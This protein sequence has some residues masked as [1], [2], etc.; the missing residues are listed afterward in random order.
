MPSLAY[1]HRTIV[2]AEAQQNVMEESTSTN[3]VI[4]AVACAQP[5]SVYDPLPKPGALQ[6]SFPDG[7]PEGGTEDITRPTDL[8]G[9]VLNN[10]AKVCDY[11]KGDS[12]DYP[13]TTGSKILPDTT[14]WPLASDPVKRASSACKLAVYDWLRRA[15]TKANV[16]SF[17]GAQGTPFDAQGADVPWGTAAP[18]PAPPVSIATI[19]RGIVHIYRFAPDGVVTYQSKDQQPQKYYV[20]ADGQVFMECFEPITDGVPGFEIGDPPPPAISLGA[21]ISASDG[22]VEFGSGYDMHIRLYSRRPGV[23]NGRHAGEPLDNPVVATRP[24]TVKLVDTSSGKASVD[25]MTI[26]GRGAASKKW[27]M[28][29]S[30]PPTPGSLGVPP[31]II[32][33]VDFMQSAPGLVNPAASWYEMY[34]APGSGV[35]VTYQQQNGTVSDIRFRRCV[36]V[37]S[38]AAPDVV[39]TGYVGSRFP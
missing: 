8:Y 38:K 24:A 2:R 37:W 29:T 33:R 28:K 34:D 30:G 16:S 23:M 3:H 15:G 27:W 22:V 19:P 31:D 5:A 35:R 20:V 9:P 4:R 10:A 17:I 36:A 39:E 11:Y 32:G 25:S 1:C 6:I 26:S 7:M 14:T 21:P 13:V 12:G 18:P